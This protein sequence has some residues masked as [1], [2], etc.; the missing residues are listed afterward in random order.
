[1]K[2]DADDGAADAVVRRLSEESEGPSGAGLEEG[3]QAPKH[4]LFSPMQLARSLRGLND[5]TKAVV[6]SLQLGGP[7][8]RLALV[9]NEYRSLCDE[10]AEDFPNFAGYIN[11]YLLP[12]LALGH[13]RN[14]PLQIPACVFVAAPGVGKTLFVAALAQKFSLGFERI[15]LETSQASFELVGTSRGWSAYQ[16]GRLFRWLAESSGPPNGIFVLEELDKA[17][18]GD[19]KYPTINALIQLLEPTTAKS[20]G[21][22]SV[23]ELKLDV[24]PVNFVCTANSLDGIPDPVLSRLLVIEVPPLSPDQ[25]RRVAM[26]QYERIVRDLELPIAAPE[27]TDAALEVLSAESPRRQRLLLQ[28]AIGRAVAER[29]RELHVQKQAPRQ[30]RGIGFY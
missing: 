4:R 7:V 8:R 5:E 19:A 16:P 29:A 24:S 3:T 15:N 2:N 1:M 17:G 25:A 20:F 12:F 26:K 6:T 18:G 10:L 28:L 23:P 30:A 13:V 14:G 11:D 27:L 21:D 22:Q 9:P